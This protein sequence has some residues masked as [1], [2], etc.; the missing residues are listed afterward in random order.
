VKSIT[1]GCL[2]VVIVLSGMTQAAFAQHAGHDPSGEAIEVGPGQEQPP[3]GSVS[4][5]TAVEVHAGAAESM[6]HGGGNTDLIGLMHGRHASGTAWMPD[7]TPSYMHMWARERWQLMLHGAAHLSY[8]EMN[9]PRGDKGVFGPNWLMFRGMRPEGCDGQLE[10]SGM[11]SLDPLTV[12]GA[13]YPLLFQTGETWKDQPLRDHQH[14]HNYFSELS[15]KYKWRAGSDQAAYLYVAPVGEP[16]LGPPA[17]MHRQFALE[18]PLSPIGHH[19]QDATH[20][21]Y[22][23]VTA[24][25]QSPEWQFEASVFN[26]RE[27]GEERYAIDEPTFDSFSGRLS[28]NPGK[29]VSM[30]V[31]RGELKE[32]EA[33]HPGEDVTR[34]TASLIYNH[35]LGCDRNWQTAFVWGRNSTGQADFDSYLVESSLKQDGG[36]SPYFRLE[37]I[38]KNA[39]EL[40]LPDPPFDHEET[41]ALKQGTVGFSVDLG[42]QGDWQWGLGG[43]YVFNLS[44]SGLD[45]VYGSNPDGW[46]VYLRAHPRRMEHG[47]GMD[48]AGEMDHSGEMDHAAGMEDSQPGGHMDEPAQ[49]TDAEDHELTADS[50]EDGEGEVE[51]ATPVPETQDGHEAH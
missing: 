11:F 45:P 9:G 8:I 3:A 33:S 27:P 44:P 29:N 21:A 51:A 37:W 36:W 47:G 35:D 13:G 46:I 30:Q 6:D 32:P 41:F 2:C 49:A 42:E 12:G 15:L 20:I 14:P 1:I 7:S 39:E 19:W 22:G 38:E 4:Q 23:V 25:L 31:S 34:T 16:A 17:F 18:A 24:G 48:H 28:W 50:A 5:D 26:G 10:F 40:V 43:A